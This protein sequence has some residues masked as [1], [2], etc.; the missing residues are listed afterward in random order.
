MSYVSIDVDID[1]VLWNMSDREKQKLVD[2]LYDEGFTPK[3][4]EKKLDPPVS[5]GESF[6]NEALNKLKGNWNR[7][8]NEE[9]QIIINIAKRF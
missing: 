7:L 3:E 5:V 1:D 9:E 2:E 4:I 6:F 8:S